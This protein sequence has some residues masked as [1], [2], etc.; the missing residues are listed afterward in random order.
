VLLQP[1]VLDSYAAWMALAARQ[2]PAGLGFL[3]ER[4]ARAGTFHMDPDRLLRGRPDEHL[5]LAATIEDVVGRGIALLQPT[6]QGEMLVFPSELRDDMSDGAPE[7]V[8]TVAFTF[9]GPVKSVFAT[10]AVCLTHAPAFTQHRLFRNA[11]VFHS[12]SGETCGFRIDYPRPQD[13]GYGSLTVFF[14]A[15]AT[16]ATKL[17][18]LRYINRQL[19]RM[20][21]RD[22]VRCERVY[23]CG[24][25]YPSPV[26]QAAL[27]WRKQR[28][29]RTVICEG[30]GAQQ[31][32]DTLPSRA[33]GW[34][35]SS[36]SRSRNP[37]RSASVSAGSR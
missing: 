36:S 25:G 16:Q 8:K 34:I 12:M 32:I 22:T 17:T 35:A 26:R 4:A 1:E 3:S 21:F 13:D 2:E 23:Y 7:D 29:E 18:F 5:L 10:L 28:G 6:E 24:C 20:A 31:P 15:A 37:T 11:A 27:E 14:D 9:E 33:S 19:Q 30:C